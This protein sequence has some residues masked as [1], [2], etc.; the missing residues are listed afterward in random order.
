MCSV[1][2]GLLTVGETK[3][4]PLLNLLS[5]FAFWKLLCTCV[6]TIIINDTISLVSWQSSKHY[7]VQLIGCK[8]N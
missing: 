6:I 7:C 8:Q 3:Q 4:I 2:A 5:T 1:A